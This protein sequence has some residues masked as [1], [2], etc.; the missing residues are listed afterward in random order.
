MCSMCV[1]SLHVWIRTFH[2]VAVKMSVGLQSS[3]G[4]TWVWKICSQGSSLTYLPNHC[5]L[6]ARCLSFLLHG[7]VQMAPWVSLW[8]IT[9]LPPEWVIQDSKIEV[10]V[11]FKIYPQESQTIVSIISYWLHRSVQKGITQGCEHQEAG[12]FFEANYHG[13]YL[14]LSVLLVMSTEPRACQIFK[15]L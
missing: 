10:T 6:L 1:S 13:L 7:P 12:I 4:F 8:N 2:E 3:N 15:A 11:S 5:W 9:W 14:P